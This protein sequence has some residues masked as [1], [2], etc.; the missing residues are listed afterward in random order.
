MRQDAVF[1]NFANTAYSRRRSRAGLSM[2]SGLTG[3]TRTTMVRHARQ[4]Q[5]IQRARARPYDRLRRSVLSVC[6]KLS[7]CA[8]AFVMPQR[9][10]MYAHVRF[11]VAHG[12]RCMFV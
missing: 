9:T 11:D 7:L 10:C 4:A 8:D 6:F 12:V 1:T 2:W 5:V 3:G